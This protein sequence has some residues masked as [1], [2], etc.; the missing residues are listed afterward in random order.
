[1]KRALLAILI[2]GITAFSIPATVAWEEIYSSH[3]TYAE[4]SEIML[5]ICYSIDA[6][7]QASSV[8]ESSISNYDI[9]EESVKALAKMLY[10]EARGVKSD[11]EKA[12][13]CWCVLNRV[14]SDSYPSTVIEVLSEPHQFLGY[15][16]DHPVTSS[17][18]A[19]AE[20]VIKRWYSE[21]DG[22]LD[23]GRVLPK[24]YYWFVGDGT[25]NHFT[26]QWKSKNYWG[27]TLE[28]PYES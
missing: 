21:K 3:A 19:L 16:P 18:Y 23:S 6:T 17:L 27:W 25:R 14:D 11:T 7:E 24:D 12:A 22:A 20:D 9:D 1:M 10:G 13:C 26:N 28:S 5:P 4:P 2:G 8:V 15:N